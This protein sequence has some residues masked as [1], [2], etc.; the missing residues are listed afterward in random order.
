MA[1]QLGKN[2]K[3]HED[4]IED[5]LPRTT[6]SSALSPSVRKNFSIDAIESSDEEDSDMFTVSPIRSAPE[7]PA[8]PTP[9]PAPPPMPTSAF[10]PSDPAVRKRWLDSVTPLK[11][12]ITPLDSRS[13]KK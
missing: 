7:P 12:A 8:S 9:L 4:Q 10:T 3:Q 1:S 13:H 5:D 2:K 6:I 11:E